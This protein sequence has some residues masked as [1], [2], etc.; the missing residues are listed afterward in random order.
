LAHSVIYF[1]LREDEVKIGLV[2]T[3]GGARA[4]YQAGV[5]KGI[6][7]ITK[8]SKAEM[9]FDIISGISA[10]AINGAMLASSHHNF[11]QVV[12]D[13]CRLWSELHPERVVNTNMATLT[14]LG[15]RWIKDLSL[16]GMFGGSRSTFLLDVRPLRTFLKEIIRFDEI[17]RNLDSGVL[18][19]FA[20]SATSYRTGTAIT[21]FDGKK[22]IEPWMRSSRLGMREKVT[23]DH[24][25]AS[26]A[27][28][29][30]FPPVQL[31]DSFFGDGSIRLSA[32]ISPAIHMGAKKVL[33]IGLRYYRPSE[34]TWSLNKRPQMDRITLADIAG[35]MLNASFFDQLDADVE[36]M[37]RI[38]QTV[39]LMSAKEREKHP[40]KLRE[41]PLLVIRPSRDLG[42]L[43]SEQFARLPGMLRY[44]LAGIGA[45]GE[46]GW[47]LLSYLAF[48]GSYTKP[49]IDLGIED[50]IAMKNEI[51][52]FLNE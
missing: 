35:V 8:S 27:I 10:G 42:S 11:G 9:P 3:G 24:V 25:L 14:R 6:F 4:A 7:E 31:D 23:L 32:P 34:V 51:L 15:T 1:G 47:D 29:I 18:H 16:G 21:F 12:D 22:E 26:A 28:P 45:S 44:L 5:L 33:A 41:I 17:Q 20:V 13:M 30:L 43:A 40:Q 46:Q 52:T 39:S 37:L 19:G 49:L 48:D 2:L 50:A 38:N 36:R